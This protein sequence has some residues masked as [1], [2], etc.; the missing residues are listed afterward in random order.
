MAEAGKMN[1]V[2]YI[3]FCYL[4]PQRL[5]VQYELNR[6]I[7]DASDKDRGYSITVSECNDSSYYLEQYIE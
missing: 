1:C 7:Y 3:R 2:L 5:I 4:T 6:A